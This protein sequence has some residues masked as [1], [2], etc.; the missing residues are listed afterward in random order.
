MAGFSFVRRNDIINDVL[1]LLHVY[2]I[3]EMFLN[4]LNLVGF[5]RSLMRQ[6]LI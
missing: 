6:D 3:T 5:T 4:S 2:I 1:N